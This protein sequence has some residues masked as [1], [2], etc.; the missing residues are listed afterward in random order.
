M[1][2]KT[3]LVTILMLTSAAQAAPLNLEQATTRIKGEFSNSGS[4]YR[5]NVS[6]GRIIGFVPGWKTPPSATALGNAGYTHVIVAFGVFSKTNPGAIVSA[7]NTV[8]KEYI[9]SLHQE[10]IKVLL[11][12]GGASSMI[13]DS[14]V[15]FDAVLKLTTPDVFKKNWLDSLFDSK[16]GLITSLGFDGIDIDIEYGINAGGSFNAPKGNDIPV[17]ADI[18]NTIHKDHPDLLI[19]YTP[20]VDNISATSGFDRAWGNYAYLI[21]Q[22]HDALSWVGIQLYNTGCALG[23]DL[24]CYDVNKLNSPDFSVAMAVDLLANWPA[25]VN[26]RNTGFQP[27]ISYLKPSQV[28]LGYPAIDASGIS[29][30]APATPTSTIKRAVECLKT[31]MVG[32]TSCQTYIPPKETLGNIGGVFNWEVTYDQNNDFKF[33]TDLK[34]C[35]INGN[36]KP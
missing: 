32:P 10:G 28:V 33:A 11:S 16:E 26:G 31:G 7:F 20:Q 22:T 25:K 23:I 4:D 34:S 1:K 21:M 13:P 6:G 18:I 15:D 29:D 27:Y 14:D 36:C 8:T 9:Q 3:L 12:I 17:L 35:V 2:L 5:E 19:S 24:T 30:G